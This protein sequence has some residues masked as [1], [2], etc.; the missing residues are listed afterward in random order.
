LTQEI[1]RKIHRASL[2]LFGS[3]MISRVIGF[4]RE[5]A[6]AH[7]IGATG[8]TDV[9]LASF[10]IPD[11]MNYLMAAGALSV[12]FIPV[13]SPYVNKGEK[14]KSERLFRS[15]ASWMG[16]L[17]LVL[18]VLAEI[19]ADHLSGLVAPGF[20]DD[21]KNL[22][23][24]LIRIILPAQFFFYWGGLANAVQQT[25]GQFLYTAL[26][27]IFYNM[28]IITFGVLLHARYGVAAFSIGVLAGAIISQGVLQWL[29]LRK[30]RY[31]IAPLFSFSPALRKDFKKYIL[32]SLP[33]MLGFSLV[34]T[35]EWISK[36]FAS[37][38]ET[39]AVSWLTYARSLM[40]MPVAVLGQV[41]GIAS[42]PFLAR[43]WA[44]K[45][46]DEYANVLVRELEKVWALA[47]LASILLMTHADSVTHF[48]YRGGKFSMSDMQHTADIL[49]LFAWG[50]PFWIAQILLA[51]AFYSAQRMWLPSLLGTALSIAII[52][53]YQ[54]WAKRF[55]VEGLALASTVG[56]CIYTFVL[57]VL[58]RLHFKKV[59]PQFSF[60]KFYLFLFAW[61]AAVVV[62][63]FL[64]QG[65]LALGLYQGTRLSGLLDAG[66][67][68]VVLGVFGILCLRT[69]FKRLTNGA[70]F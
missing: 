37:G 10:T 26:G 42:Y 11:F 30:L 14:E 49:R 24:Q 67:T 33:I 17:F 51:R 54:L 52:P 5:L 32:L 16:A 31:R 44:S 29:G 43:L 60:K 3:M 53:L 9:Y 66:V 34:V 28:G 25:H 22:L 2:L 64:S 50:I 70:L 68:T 20:S 46:Y 57:W 69:V 45:S 6:L 4:F 40:R 19:F 41:A 8:E 39:R 59:A 36:Y 61:G 7:F 1:N 15:V 23:T 38:L 18:L 62:A 56:I 21:Q 13:I 55:G 63:W 35:D 58:L 12:S 27:G 65:C 47:P 48:V